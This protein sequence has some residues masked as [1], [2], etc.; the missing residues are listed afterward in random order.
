MKKRTVLVPTLL[1]FISAHAA[2]IT[3]EYDYKLDTMTFKGFVAYDDAIKGKRP[4]VLVAHEWWGLNDFTKTQA[5]R[6]AQSGYVA[7][8]V[9]MYG[10]GKTTADFSIAA[11]LA[12]SVRGTPLMRKRIIAGL[13]ALLLQ[14]NVDPRRIAAI[15]FCFGG[16]SVLDL[17]YSG[18]DVKG[19]V[20]FHGG[21]FS[22]PQDDL[23]NIKARILVLHG[24]D[25]PTM[26]PDT[27]RAFQES[28]R[29]SG[30][31]WQMV[32]F[33]NAVHSFSNPASGNDKSKGIAYNPLAAQRSWKDMEDFLKDV[34]AEK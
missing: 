23:K 18:A 10:A 11:K 21:L 27:V 24:A 14:E 34:L 6:L 33:G 17:A 13:D 15:G 16:T 1:F 22:V 2:M 19:V 31:D 28:M 8:A 9:D 4:G 20:T 26:K 12:G 30:A 29:K 7:F 25:D 32:Y 5:K 3:K